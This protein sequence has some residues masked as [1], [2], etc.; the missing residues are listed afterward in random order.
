MGHFHFP[1]LN[2]TVLGLKRTVSRGL[3]DLIDKLSITGRVL[4]KLAEAI[5]YRIMVAL[6]KEN[7]TN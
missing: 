1:F 7:N 3:N 5:S 2:R 4:Y 6:Y